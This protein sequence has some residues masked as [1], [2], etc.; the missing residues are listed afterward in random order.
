MSFSRW[1]GPSNA[2]PGDLE[3][4][5]SS[6]HNTGC[7]IKSGMTYTVVL[8]VTEQRGVLQ[9]P[10]AATNKGCLIMNEDFFPRSRRT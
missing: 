4:I 9:A 2:K 8:A 3:S 7:R 1:P 10:D 5:F 6:P